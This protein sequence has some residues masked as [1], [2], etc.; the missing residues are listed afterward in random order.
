M[1]SG[2]GAPQPNAPCSTRFPNDSGW[3]VNLAP[4]RFMIGSTMADPAARPTLLKA[5]NEAKE[6]LNALRQR[7]LGPVFE[8]WPALRWG[9]TASGDYKKAFDG[10]V[11]ELTKDDENRHVLLAAANASE[12]ADET[13][14]N[15]EAVLR[16]FA[17][18]YKHMIEA[19]HLREH[20][21]AE[22]KARFER[23]WQAEQSSLP[24]GTARA[25]KDH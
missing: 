2:A 9:D 24:L 11:E 21:K 16:R 5:Q 10:I 25:G 22:I 19:Q 23:L 4:P 14:D 17:T 20:G 7:M 13:V 3:K 1:K 6:Q 12:Q 8:R 15:E 18:L